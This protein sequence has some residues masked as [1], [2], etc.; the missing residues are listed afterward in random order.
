MTNHAR[1]RC[2]QMGVETKRVK[3]LVRD[4]DITRPSGEGIMAKADYDPEIV[5]VYKEVE[6]GTR[7]ILTVL[8]NTTEVFQRP[9]AKKEYQP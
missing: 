4:P 5:V 6:D 7:I 8:P 2:E 3:R 1:L 9:D